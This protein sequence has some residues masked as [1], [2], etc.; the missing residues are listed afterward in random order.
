MEFL[1]RVN[2][3][4][5]DLIWQEI[6]S[7]LGEY[8]S[9]RLTLR[10]VVDFKDEYSYDTDSIS[11]K[12]ISTLK[13]DKGLTI[14][15]REPISMV[16]VKKTFSLPKSVLE[17]IQRG[18]SDYDDSAF[19]E[20]ANDFSEIE[21]SIILSGLLEANINGIIS[22]SEIKSMKIKSTKDI[23]A[24]VAKA[25][26]MFNKEFVSGGFKLV[27]SSQ[28]MGKLYTELFDGVSIKSELDNILGSNEIVVNQTIGND[29]ALIISQRGGDFEFYSGL[30]VCVGFEKESAKSIELFLLQTLAFRVINPEAAILLNLD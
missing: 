28:T 11:T 9:K 23:L 16:E 2:A 6:D 22:N 1:N 29:K 19:R 4:F 12:K 10:S 14:S 13:D 27:I 18:V 20:A 17:D 5:G 26:G 21:N 8:L 15:K 25:M 30:D 24:G 7:L 3:P